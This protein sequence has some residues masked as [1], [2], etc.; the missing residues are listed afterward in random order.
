MPSM[1]SIP[2]RISAFF[3]LVTCLGIEYKTSPLNSWLN[4][5]HFYLPENSI[6]FL[7]MLEAAREARE[8]TEATEAT[9]VSKMLSPREEYQLEKALTASRGIMM[10]HRPLVPTIEGKKY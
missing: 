3:A 8:A 2:R 5:A 6:V 1:P 9:E 7:Q 10:R 4:G